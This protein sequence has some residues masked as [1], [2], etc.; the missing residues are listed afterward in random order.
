MN[1]SPENPIRLLDLNKYPLNDEQ[2]QDKQ[3]KK[4][5]HEVLYEYTPNS[6]YKNSFKNTVKRKVYNL[7]VNKKLSN[8]GARHFAPIYCGYTRKQIDDIRKEAINKYSP[9][10]YG[11]LTT[12]HSSA[13][14]VLK[15]AQMLFPESKWIIVSSLW[16]SY[17]TNIDMVTLKTLFTTHSKKELDPLMIDHA[18]YD[19]NAPMIVDILITNKNDFLNLVALVPDDPT[20]TTNYVGETY[21]SFNSAK[22]YRKYA[23]NTNLTKKIPKNL[24]TRKNTRNTITRNTKLK[25]CSNGICSIMG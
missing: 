7:P 13:H 8:Y 9:Y 22:N 4:W 17:V 12:C 10:W 18:D 11:M 5:T 21:E 25:K 24:N 19:V 6:N 3:L 2:I 16:H 1:I 15:I 23:L 14:I 20:Y